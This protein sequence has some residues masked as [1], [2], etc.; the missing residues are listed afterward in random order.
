MLGPF[1]LLVAWASVGS[2]GFAELVAKAYAKLKERDP[3]KAERIRRGAIAVTRTLNRGLERLPERW[4]RGLYLPD[5][6]TDGYVPERL[7]VDP[8]EDLAAEV[9]AA[10]RAE[11]GA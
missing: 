9:Q 4:T 8:F 2:D 7:M 1:A 6:E 10:K 5:F 3:G 11:S